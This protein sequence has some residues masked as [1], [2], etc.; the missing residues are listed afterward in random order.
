MCEYVHAWVCLCMCMQ[1]FVQVLDAARRG[2]TPPGLKSQVALS[3]LQHG[4]GDWTPVLR[5]KSKCSQPGPPLQGATE[6][7][8]VRSVETF[9]RAHLTH[10][11]QLST[12]Q[13][14]KSKPKSL[15]ITC[16]RPW[17]PGS[18]KIKVLGR[19]SYHFIF[20]LSQVPFNYVSDKKNTPLNYKS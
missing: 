12:L 16:W 13:Q 5:R 15:Q 4:A 9:T 20:W 2:Q 8:C 10:R 6:L 7:T 3:C 1:A 19:S 14:K 11:L 18:N 17:N